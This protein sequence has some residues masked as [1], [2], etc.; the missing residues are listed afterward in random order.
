MMELSANLI[1]N[2]SVKNVTAVLP[3]RQHDTFSY[4]RVILMIGVIV[5]GEGL[6][7]SIGCVY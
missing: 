7:L 2:R 4:L 3:D 6:A 5:G 1:A